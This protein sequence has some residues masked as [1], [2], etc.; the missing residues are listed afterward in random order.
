MGKDPESHFKS[1]IKRPVSIN[2]LMSMFA[3]LKFIGEN[4]ANPL[5]P[6]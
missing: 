2:Q 4:E 3:N 6:E 1:I 5:K